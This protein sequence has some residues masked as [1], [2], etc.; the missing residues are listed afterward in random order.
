MSMYRPTPSPRDAESPND[1]PGVL[2]TE[3][4][5]ILPRVGA[6]VL[7]YLI[8][9]LLAV[10]VGVAVLL[11]T[12]NQGL[13]FLAVGSTMFGYYIILEGAFGQTVGKRVAGVV[14]VNRDGQPI[15]FSE[16]FIRNILRLIDGIFNY[17]VGLVVMLLTE[18][19]QRVGDLAAGTVVVRKQR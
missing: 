13:G 1:G 17:A 9:F 11:S 18:D 19:R 5:V 3:Q 10:I 15:G 14:V 4:S 6:F 8:S 2:G 7:D 12:H 16:S